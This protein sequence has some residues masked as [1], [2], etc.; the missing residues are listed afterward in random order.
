M[1]LF[2]Q[3]PKI[4]I[5]KN[6]YFFLLKDSKLFLQFNGFPRTY[7]QYCRHAN[8]IS[9]DVLCIAAGGILYV[10]WENAADFQQF[11]GNIRWCTQW[12]MNLHNSKTIPIVVLVNTGWNLIL[13]F[14]ERNSDYLKKFW[15][16]EEMLDFISGQDTEP[17]FS[18]LWEQCCAIGIWCKPQHWKKTMKCDHDIA[19]QTL[20]F[21]TSIL[22][23]ITYI[24]WFVSQHGKVVFQHLGL[25]PFHKWLCLCHT[26]FSGILVLLR[27][28]HFDLCYITN[29][30]QKP[31]PI[32]LPQE[33]VGPEKFTFGSNS[34]VSLCM[35][36]PGRAGGLFVCHMACFCC[37]GC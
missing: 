30:F 12:L 36:F 8:C 15:L 37:S 19:M 21:H 28:L 35:P 17:D 20:S 10:V 25:F 4:N 13:W 32:I 2:F 31:L 9:R 1:C 29:E 14:A 22:I 3:K 18:T 6:P 7:G 11:L 16:F 27:E 23:L 34:N 33:S 26:D 24:M 5:F